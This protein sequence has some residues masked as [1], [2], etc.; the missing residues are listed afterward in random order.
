MIRSGAAFALRAVSTPLSLGLLGA[1]FVYS[2]QRRMLQLEIENRGRDRPRAQEFIRSFGENINILFRQN[3]EN[4]MRPNQNNL[5]VLL[6]SLNNIQQNME[7]F[8]GDKENDELKQLLLESLNTFIELLARNSNFTREQKIQIITI[9]KMNVESES[10]LGSSEGLNIGPEF[11]NDFVPAQNTPTRTQTTN[12]QIREEQQ[13]LADRIR[14]EGERLGA[15]TTPATPA[16]PPAAP[17]PEAAAT[18]AAPAAT[19][20]NN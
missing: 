17:A 16:T 11:T 10:I 7:A 18:P 3:I 8:L 13:E 2:L 15:Q 12:R 19:V 1:E 20:I 4:G 5:D 6:R 14:R 9:I